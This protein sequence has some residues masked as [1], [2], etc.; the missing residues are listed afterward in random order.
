M[1]FKPSFRRK[2][3]S[4]VG[5]TTADW[6]PAFAGMTDQ[7]AAYTPNFE[8]RINSTSVKLRVGV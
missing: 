3:E 7:V 5:D 2:P 1:V 4:S 8:R 6:I